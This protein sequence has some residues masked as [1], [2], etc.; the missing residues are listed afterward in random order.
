MTQVRE[1]RIKT[2]K[3]EAVF[4]YTCVCVSV[5]TS[6]VHNTCRIENKPYARESL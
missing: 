6:N 2:F 1:T 4:L 5:Y 3:H